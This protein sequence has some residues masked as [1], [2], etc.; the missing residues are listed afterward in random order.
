[1]PY[2]RHYLPP[3]EFAAARASEDKTLAA[4]GAP[5]WRGGQLTDQL[6]YVTCPK[7]AAAA[8]TQA[9]ES[10]RRNGTTL[11]LSPADKP[12]HRSVRSIYTVLLCSEALCF[13]EFPPGWR[14]HWRLV[15]DSGVPIGKTEYAA[16]EQAVADV[17]R[18][19]VDGVLLTPRAR[20]DRHAQ[21]NREREVRRQRRDQAEQAARAEHSKNQRLLK[22]AADLVGRHE[23][24]VPEARA[25][26][27]LLL[28]LASKPYVDATLN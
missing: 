8:G 19:I 10:A 18:L 21:L 27:E 20:A 24:E 15:D 4:C 23:N 9:I 26:R 6:A 12:R 16:K 25:A 3:A 1:M 11:T 14:S 13:V 17:P 2:H 22:I 7:C 28:L 5:T